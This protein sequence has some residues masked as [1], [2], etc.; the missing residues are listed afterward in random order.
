MRELCFIPLGMMKMSN[1]G[2]Y[3]VHALV[4]LAFNA[5]NE[6]AQIHDI[7]Q[8]ARVPQR[9][10]EQI[11]HDLKRAGFLESK[12]GPRG[13]YQL[14]QPPEQI[15]MGDVLRALEGPIE[16]VKGGRARGE[17][18]LRQVADAAFSDLAREIER[19]FDA[20]TLEDLCAKGEA[21]GLARR[22]RH[23][24]TAYVI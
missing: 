11:F 19:C 9:F 23:A 13:G 4:D 6:P 15:R 7:A 5:G 10:L 3:A 2:R 18:D 1:K 14:A 21:L 24:V 16:L 20:V 17:A 22:G 8:R 12:R